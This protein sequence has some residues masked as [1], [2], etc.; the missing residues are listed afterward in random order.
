MDLYYLKIDKNRK[1]KYSFANF[2]NT[3]I[4]RHYILWGIGILRVIFAKKHTSVIEI[5]KK[6]SN[7]SNS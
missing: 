2:L 3:I 1:I 6:N 4:L 5:N 7:H